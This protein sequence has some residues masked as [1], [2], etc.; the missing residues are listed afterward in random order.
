MK[1]KIWVIHKMY[2]LIFKNLYVLKPLLFTFKKYFKNFFYVNL[3]ILEFLPF[4]NV[5]PYY[6]ESEKKMF[7]NSK[8]VCKQILYMINNFSCI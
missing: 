2:F 3:Q 1:Y 7:A 5:D 8:L 4:E 6:C